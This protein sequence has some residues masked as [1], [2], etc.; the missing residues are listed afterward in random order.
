MKLA[1]VSWNRKGLEQEIR[2][3]GFRISRWWPEFVVCAGGDGTFLF[4]E[5]VYP[6]VPKLLLKHRCTDK[7]KDHK[8][9]PLLQ[10]L[11][12]GQFRIKKE[13]KVAA[14]VNKNPRRRL[15]GMN[16]INI[17]YRLPCAVG[18]DVQVG[19][20]SIAKGVMG[21][22]LIVATPYGSS[23]Y[24]HSIA[25]KTFTKGLGLA[26][27]NPTRPVRPRVVGEGSL[28]RAKVVKHSG[29]VAADC[30]K[31]VL[32]LREGDT[33]EIRKHAK[34][35]QIVVLKGKKEKIKL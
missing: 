31:R 15:V 23:A 26:F 6:G 30:N 34:P 7:C 13:I 32:P 4:G 27:N 35:A 12:K 25:K 19:R 11:A 3:A 24:F 10:K 20:K 16:E 5:Q 8:L 9:A 2:E 21:D 1:V 28:I 18:L 33:V 22:G 17:H 29:W 14:T